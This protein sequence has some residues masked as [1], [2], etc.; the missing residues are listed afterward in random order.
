MIFCK[1]IVT[2]I[3]ACCFLLNSGVSAEEKGNIRGNCWGF[4]MNR[5]G[6]GPINVETEHS[7]YDENGVV[8]SK[9]E[10]GHLEFDKFGRAYIQKA[11][12]GEIAP[13]QPKPALPPVKDIEGHPEIFQKVCPRHCSPE[14]CQRGDRQSVIRAIKQELTELGNFIEQEAIGRGGDESGQEEAYYLVKKR[15]HRL[16]K[17][18]KS[19]LKENKFQKRKKSGR[20]NLFDLW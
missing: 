19:L 5:D 16:K 2:G 4:Y 11:D 8:Q 6:E 9:K 17:V 10:S 1:K 7:V 18:A 3:F 15:L 12:G 20:F 13:G 14:N